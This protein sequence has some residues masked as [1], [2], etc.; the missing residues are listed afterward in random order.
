MNNS[1]IYLIFQPR[2]VSDTDEAD[3]QRH[4]AELEEANRE[5]SGDE[6]DNEDEESEENEGDS[7]NSDQ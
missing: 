5:V 1:S 4:M 7:D 3:L 6:D 2:L